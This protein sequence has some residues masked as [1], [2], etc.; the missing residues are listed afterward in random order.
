MK[1]HTICVKMT[2]Q[3]KTCA[4]KTFKGDEMSFIGYKIKSLRMKAGL[5]Q[6][7]LAEKLGGISASAVGMYEQGRRT[8]DMAMVVRLGELFGVSTDSL[9][10]VKGESVEAI[11]ILAELRNRVSNSEV[12][13]LN[14][15][16]MTEESREKLLKAIE[17]IGNV[18]LE[19]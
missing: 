16:V 13:T 2:R 3:S 1:Y 11:E 10:G 8:P 4:E 12:L 6:Q 15:A 9:L 14:G 7:Q 19:A 17:F 5:T 18:V